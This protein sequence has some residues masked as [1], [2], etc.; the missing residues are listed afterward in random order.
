MF[1]F[2]CVLSGVVALRGS[3]VKTLI[4][5][6]FANISINLS[7]SSLVCCITVMTS[8]LKLCGPATDLGTGP[9]RTGGPKGGLPRGRHSGLLML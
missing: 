5:R 3:P 2:R 4:I 9:V 1:C 7:A 8:L 6:S